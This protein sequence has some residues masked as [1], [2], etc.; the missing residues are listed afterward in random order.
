MMPFVFA[1]SVLLA[2]CTSTTPASDNTMSTDP[3][4]STPSAA[5]PP[6]MASDCKAEAAQQFVGQKATPEVVEAARVAAGAAI[7]RALRPDMPTT[8]DYR[9]DRLNLRTDTNDVVASV[10]CG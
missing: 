10:D 8:M 2:A 6:S 7:V 9:V 1:A 4:A 5:A 3:A